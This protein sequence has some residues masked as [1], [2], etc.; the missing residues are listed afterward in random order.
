MV[1]Q[2]CAPIRKRGSR[3]STGLDYFVPSNVLNSHGMEVNTS[4]SALLLGRG[5]Q[6]VPTVSSTLSFLVLFLK[7]AP[8]PL[9]TTVLCWHFLGEMQRRSSLPT[10]A[11]PIFTLVY[12]NFLL[13]RVNTQ[14]PVAAVS[15]FLQQPAGIEYVPTANT[16]ADVVQ[17]DLLLPFFFFCGIGLQDV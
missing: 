9:N 15:L 10:E 14:K 1:L 13:C 11:F 7:R 17:S 3:P 8:L 4:F 2:C 6:G 5:S 16:L 12:A